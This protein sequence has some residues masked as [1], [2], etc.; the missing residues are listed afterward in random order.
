MADVLSSMSWEEWGEF[1]KNPDKFIES[2]HDES[3]SESETSDIENAEKN[4]EIEEKY[5]KLAEDRKLA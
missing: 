3:E 5:T 4:T 1:I 2:F